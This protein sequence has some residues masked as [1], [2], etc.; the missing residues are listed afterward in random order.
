MQPWPWYGE[1]GTAA[2]SGRVVRCFDGKDPTRRYSP[3]WSARLG[4]WGASGED[5]RQRCDLTPDELRELN[6]H[7]LDVLEVALC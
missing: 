3:S 4:R 7:V 2:W 5:D 1:H 6:S